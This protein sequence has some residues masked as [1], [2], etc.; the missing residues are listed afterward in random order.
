MSSRCM[1]DVRLLSPRM[2]WLWEHFQEIVAGSGWQLR[3]ISTW[4]S[5]AEQENLIREG[6]AAERCSWHLTGEAFDIAGSFKPVIGAPDRSGDIAT[7]I[8]GMPLLLKTLGKEAV[9]QG[10]RWGGNF[11]KPDTNH[12]DDGVGRRSP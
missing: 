2:R 5:D 4:R 1:N 9:N 12:F 10:Y 8:V 11:A 3:L 7:G 6:S